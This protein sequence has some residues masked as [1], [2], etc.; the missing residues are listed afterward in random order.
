MK[1]FIVI[2][3][4]L[5]VQSCFAEEFVSPETLSLGECLSIALENHPSLRKGKASTRAAEAS[6]EQ[7]KSSNRIKVNM[8]GSANVNGDYDEPES[9]INSG[10]AGINASKVL[11]DTGVN[12]LNRQIQAENLKGAQESERQT[13]ITVAAGAKRA[14]YDLVL[15]YL[16]RDVERE[17]LNNL[18]EH[19]KTAQGFYDVG[20]NAFIEVT[21]AQADVSSARVSVLQAENDISV[22][23]EALKTAMGIEHYTAENIGLSTQ[24]NLPPTEDGDTAS[25]LKTALDDRAD[26]QRIQ[27]VIQMRE[28]QVNAAARGSSPTLNG[29][30][31]SEMRKQES[32]NV[33]KNYTAGLT[34][35]I[36]VL[37][38]GQTRAE[39]SSARA[40]L[41]QDTADADSLRQTIAHDV[42]NAVL[43]LR[44]AADR[45]RSSEASV[46]YAEENLA[47]AR[48]R[49]EV[50][51]GDA[52]ELSDAVSALASSRYAHYQA[53]Y[54]A[55]IAR[56]NLDEAMGHLPEE[57][58]A[59]GSM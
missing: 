51:V 30:L 32:M 58:N 18:E 40:Q 12:R 39:V 55:Q 29:S 43:S 3:L 41:E 17:K 13:R 48:G 1:K 47:L 37:D 19:L 23:F 16:N 21:K 15:K 34:L 22:S 4:I 24:L 52:L 27:H 7:V 9:R 20:N 25:L 33:V 36:P 45:A 54:D 2:A 31:G 8:T 59:E 49:Y 35:N 50:G 38:G 26:Y 6:L 56:T 46:K 28:L 53:L 57:L 5:S 11:Y 14:Y 42:R 10:T 44:N